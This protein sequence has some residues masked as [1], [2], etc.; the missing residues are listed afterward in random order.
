MHRYRSL[1]TGGRRRS[2]QPHWIPTRKGQ[3]AK[4]VV[5]YLTTQKREVAD[6]STSYRSRVSVS[7][8]HGF[9]L[10]Y[11]GRQTTNNNNKKRNNE[12]STPP[13]PASGTLQYST[14]LYDIDMD[15]P[16]TVQQYAVPVPVPDLI[17]RMSCFSPFY[18]TSG[19]LVNS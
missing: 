12:D 11:S 1:A 3:A 6:E 14:V 9:A 18:S 10:S 2:Q 8:P 15:R 13:I 7:R 19:S 17:A 16:I 4:T 5:C